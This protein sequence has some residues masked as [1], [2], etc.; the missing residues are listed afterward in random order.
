MITKKTR[1]TKSKVMALFEQ[2]DPRYA[3]RVRWN[4]AVNESK[5]GLIK[6]LFN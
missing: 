5:K 1:P 3:F 4:F 2:K 6:L